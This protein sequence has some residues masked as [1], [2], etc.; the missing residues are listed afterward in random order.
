M[1]E[2]TAPPTWSTEGEMMGTPMRVEID[3]PFVAHGTT[4]RLRDVEVPRSFVPLE[5]ATSERKSSGAPPSA[6]T[7]TTTRAAAIC[8]AYT[9]GSEARSF[10][11]TFGPNTTVPTPSTES[12]KSLRAER[13]RKDS[14]VRL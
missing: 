4:L 1:I 12:I 10:T 11:T 7:T 6:F 9:A 8:S 2:V 14:T 13:S 3:T 5:L